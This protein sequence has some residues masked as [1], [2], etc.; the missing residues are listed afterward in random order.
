VTNFQGR[1]S[2]GVFSPNL[3]PELVIYDR[4]NFRGSSRTMTAQSSNM[5]SINARSGS[6]EVRSGTWQLCDRD[7]RC[8]TVSQNVSD[9]SQLGLN[10][11]ITSVRPLNNQQN[12]RGYGRGRRNRY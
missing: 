3:S 9:L 8:A 2:G 4:P 5:G 1:R 7:G 12:D 11:R 6:V 10:G